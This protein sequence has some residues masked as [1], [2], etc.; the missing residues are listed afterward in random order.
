MLVRMWRKC[1]SS[2]LLA[3]MGIGTDTMENSKVPQKLPYD[4][5]I[6][7]LGV[8]LKK[9]K[10]PNRKDICTPMFIEALFTIANIWKQPVSI[11]K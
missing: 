10:T 11:N 7:L 4:P 2:T 1:N 5:E 3:G 8:F 9:T 6:P